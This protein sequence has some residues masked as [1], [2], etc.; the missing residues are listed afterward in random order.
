MPKAKKAMGPPKGGPWTWHTREML[1][2]PAWQALG[3]NAR[4]FLDFLEIDHMDHGGAENGNLMAT[5]DQLEA[6]GI[7]RDQICPAIEQAIA[8][9]FVKRTSPRVMRVAMTYRLTYYGTITGDGLALQPS[10]D[11]K[12]Y[13]EE[14]AVAAKKKARRDRKKNSTGT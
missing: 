11:W 14:S 4:R 13:N 2:S 1:T 3:I 6:H 5:Y 9:G 7:S 10:N 8:L 12:K